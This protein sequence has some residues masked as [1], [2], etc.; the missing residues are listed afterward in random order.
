MLSKPE[1]NYY[2]N[3][4]L[5]FFGVVYVITEIIT[6]INP[7]ALIPFLIDIKSIQEYTLYA[8]AVLIL[9]HPYG[10]DQSNDKDKISRRKS[11]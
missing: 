3:I 2:L 11:A 9:I 4:S 6:Y 8:L 5:L 1:R 10:Q 7:S